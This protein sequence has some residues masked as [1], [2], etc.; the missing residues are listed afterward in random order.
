MFFSGRCRPNLSVLLKLVSTCLSLCLVSV[1]SADIDGARV[2]EGLNV[3]ASEVEDLE[4]GDVLT[5]SDEAYENTSRDLSADA[6]LL[7]DTDLETVKKALRDVVTILPDKV[8]LDHAEI[9]SE[10][11]FVR[12]LYSESEIEEVEELIKSGPGKEFNFSTAEYKIINA[13][14]NPVLKGSTSEKIKAASTSIHDILVARYNSY[15]ANGLGG[16]ESYTRSKRKKT[17]IREELLLATK[18]FAPFRNDFPEYYEVMENYPEG[19]ACCEH[20]YRW[21]KLDI[22]DRPTFVLTHTIIQET[23]DYILFTER[24]YFVSNTINSMQVTLSWLPYDEN[25]YMGLA[26]SASADILNSVLGRML[27]PLGRNKA[28]KMVSDVVRD[29]RVTLQNDDSGAAAVVEK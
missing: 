13:A 16:I 14:G 22:R 2:L 3:S 15:R 5:F 19:A 24:F 11:D 25:T 9:N 27:R 17:N 18:T 28:K 26:M 20:K 29:I 4:K 12:V 1:A 6:I 8:L 7:V 21:L 10:A 23:Q